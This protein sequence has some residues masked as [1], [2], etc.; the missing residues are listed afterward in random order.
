MDNYFGCSI[1]SAADGNCQKWLGGW[2]DIQINV[3]PTKGHEQI[4]HPVLIM[5]LT[6]WL[7]DAYIQNFRLYV[8]GPSGFWTMA[9]LRYATI[10][11]CHL[12]TLNNS[13]KHSV[14]IPLR[15][16]SK[17]KVGIDWDSIVGKARWRPSPG[18]IR[19]PCVCSEC[20]FE[21]TGKLA[22]AMLG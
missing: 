3:N 21:G 2:W 22:N 16:A 9:P 13:I 17:S 5:K 1:V 8:F 20:G 15:L 6:P 14:H 18:R 10:K 19:N 7:P 4:G 12:A 11:F